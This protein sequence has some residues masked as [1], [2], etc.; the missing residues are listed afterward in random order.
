MQVIATFVSGLLLG[1]GL[2]VSGLINPAKVLN[3]LDITGSW[4]ASL[5]LTMGA[6]VVTTG[7]GYLFVLAKPAPLLGG[8]FHLPPATA[9][10]GRLITGAAL[11]GIGWGVVGYCPGPAIA[12]LSAGSVSTFVFVAAMLAGMAVSRALT[13]RNV[14]GAK[15]ATAESTGGTP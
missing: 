11:F 10:D 1:L 9:V 6:A 5:A 2:V 12:A 15:T 13:L 14:G 8:N 3:F 7:L 4:D